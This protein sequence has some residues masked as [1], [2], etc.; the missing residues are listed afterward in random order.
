[1]GDGQAHAMFEIANDVLDLG[2]GSVVSLEVEH[3]AVAVGDKGVVA[4]LGEQRELL[5]GVG[6]TRRTI[7]RTGF[8]PLLVANGV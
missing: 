3:V 2:V 4:E 7:K 5:P 8:A 1:M 6:G